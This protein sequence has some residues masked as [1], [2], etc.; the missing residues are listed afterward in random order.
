MEYDWDHRVNTTAGTV[1][2]RDR[3]LGLFLSAY[4]PTDPA[5]FQEMMAALPID[6]SDYTFVDL[7]SGKGRTLL[8]ASEFPF[9]RIIGV[10]VVPDLHLGAEQN[11]RDYHSPT[12]RCRAIE[13]ICADAST[14]LL[15]L[16][17][18]VLYLFNPFSE[19]HLDQVLANLES[20]LR[21]RPRSVYVLYHN[22]L[23]EES[24][25]RQSWIEVV[26]RGEQFSLFRHLPA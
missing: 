5:A 15:P 24:L 26:R 14:F 10:E 4:Q 18:L 3:L 16:D 13:S 2:W 17:P 25:R 1:G 12:Q 21:E 23:L 9:C 11:I 20:S 22:P 19:R 7:G 6:F 8:M